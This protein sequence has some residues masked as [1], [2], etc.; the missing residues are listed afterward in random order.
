[1]QKLPYVLSYCRLSGTVKMRSVAITTFVR[2]RKCCCKFSFIQEGI[3]N[4]RNLF[5][6][7][8]S[9]VER[10]FFFFTF[11]RPTKQRGEGGMSFLFSSSKIALLRLSISQLEMMEDVL[12]CLSSYPAVLW[13]VIINKEWPI[14]IITWLSSVCV[15]VDPPDACRRGPCCSKSDSNIPW[16]ICADCD[17]TAYCPSSRPERKDTANSLIRLDPLVWLAIGDSENSPTG[18]HLNFSPLDTRK[19]F[20]F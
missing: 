10:H 2:S 14:Q 6:C 5:C 4:G 12:L 8:G 20:V 17:C 13:I 11:C 18:K 15:C 1:M 3:E 7:F 19:T 16:R 9:S